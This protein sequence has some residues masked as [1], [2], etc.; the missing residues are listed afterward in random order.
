MNSKDVDK[1]I[2]KAKHIA[3]HYEC[4]IDL[5]NVGYSQ[6]N[7]DTIENELRK[8]I[9]RNIP[10]VI[11]NVNGVNKVGTCPT[12]G[13]QFVWRVY[14]IQFCEMCGQKIYWGVR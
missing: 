9:G 4:L 12:C 2:R 3:H 13:Y 5:K 10:K 8:V 6:W 14:T 7:S 1:A 11:N